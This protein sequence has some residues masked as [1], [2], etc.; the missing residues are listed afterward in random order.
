MKF[1]EDL[2][3]LIPF[4]Y[5]F[6]VVMGILKESV[7]F[8]QLGINILKYSTL[9]DILI[10]PIATLTTHP[11]TFIATISI[12]V[13]C[14][15]LPSILY[16][17]DHKKWIRKIFE[18]KQTKLDLPEV[19]IKKY[20]AFISIKFLAVGLLSVYL[21]YGTAEGFMAA[22]RIREGK[23]KYDYTLNY[24]NGGTE[25]I[26]LINTN[27]VYYFYVSKGSKTIKIAP[28]GAIKNIEL[29]NNRMFKNE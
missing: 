20:Y 1:S 17:N 3:K 2:Q 9:M 8:Y 4:G 27:T 25:Q 19:E 13:I 26:S 16:K 14:Y 21:G 12:F 24:S 11:I 15:Y 5:L 7:I 18:L 29:T 10:S 23:L 22:K 28:I 6:L